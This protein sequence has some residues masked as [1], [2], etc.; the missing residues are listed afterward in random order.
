MLIRVRAAVL[1]RLPVGRSRRRKKVTCF[2]NS[3]NGSTVREMDANVDGWRSEGSLAIE[4]RGIRMEC[5]EGKVHIECSAEWGHS[6]D[7]SI[8]RAEKSH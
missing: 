5:V 6:S 3:S 1:T 4:K 2:G 8:N 7:G